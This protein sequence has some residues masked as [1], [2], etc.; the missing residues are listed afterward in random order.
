MGKQGRT[1]MLKWGPRP[2]VWLTR[3]KNPQAFAEQGGWGCLKDALG[4]TDLFFVSTESR[5]CSLQRILIIRLQTFV[6]LLNQQRVAWEYISSFIPSATA[7]QEKVPASPQQLHKFS[8]MMGSRDLAVVR[9]NLVG[10]RYQHRFHLT[11]LALLY[12]CTSPL[13]SK[14]SLWL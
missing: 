10:V 6:T 4:T 13:S 5:K 12:S 3:R 11:S 14:V 7:V 9:C 2:W 8:E 1:H